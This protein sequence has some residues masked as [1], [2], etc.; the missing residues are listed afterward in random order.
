MKKIVE[1]KAAD[2]TCEVGDVIFLGSKLSEKAELLVVHKSEY[3]DVYIFKPLSDNS[4]FMQDENGNIPFYG[5][6]Y[7]YA[8]EVEVKEE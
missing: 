4:I 1:Y 6:P 8:K 5:I 3:C 2:G 7:I